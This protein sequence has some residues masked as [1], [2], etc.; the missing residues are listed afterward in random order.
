VAVAVTTMMAPEPPPD[1]AFDEVDQHIMRSGIAFALPRRE[2][3]VVVLGINRSRLDL[4]C[5]FP[6]ETRFRLGFFLLTRLMHMGERETS[7]LAYTET[8]SVSGFSKALAL[9]MVRVL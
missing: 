9:S 5:S 2:D 6:R 3:G 4:F 7:L 8:T 1:S